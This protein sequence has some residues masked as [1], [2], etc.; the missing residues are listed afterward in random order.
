MLYDLFDLNDSNLDNYGEWYSKIM[1]LLKA[2]RKKID[3]QN[4]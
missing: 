2:Y 4:F 1:E 3:N